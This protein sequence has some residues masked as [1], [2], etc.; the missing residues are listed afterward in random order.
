M[1]KL[2]LLNKSMALLLSSCFCLSV[3]A[4]PIT[5]KVQC[6]SNDNDKYSYELLQ[7]A[8]SYSNNKYQTAVDPAYEK[9]LARTISEVESGVTDVMWTATDRE[10]ENLILP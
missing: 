8:L 10:K 1:H 7:L 2:N 4:A 3:L 5:L 6:V 9:T